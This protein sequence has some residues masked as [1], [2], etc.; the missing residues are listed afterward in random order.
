[1]LTSIA[2]VFLV[3]MFL[4]WLFKKI[5]LP[6]LI[7]MIVTGILLGPYVL[8]VLDDSIL[9]VSADLRQMAL[10]IILFR[11]GLSLKIDDF[12]KMGSSAIF[13]SFVPALFEIGAVLILGTLLFDLNLVEAALM[14]SVLA[15]VSPAVVVPSMLR[16]IEKGYGQE[17]RVPQLVLAGAA[18]D[19]I[20]VIVLFSSFLAL[21]LGSNFSAVTIIEVPLAI[22]IGLLTGSIIGWV[23]QLFYR[24]FHMRDTTKVIILLSL[25]FLLLELEELISEFIPF[26]GLLAIMA[27]GLTLNHFYP[28]LADRLSVKYNKLWTG[29][30]I[31]LF[32]LVGASVDVRYA[33]RAGVPVILLIIGALMMRMIGVFVSLLPSSLNKKEKFF[34]M[35]SYTPKATVQAAIGGVPLAMGLES[36]QLILTV[37]VLSILITAPL[38]SLAIEKTY[39]KLLNHSSELINN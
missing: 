28:I 12:K 6:S 9:V 25:S 26:S 11:A 33:L 37:A 7:G 4:G 5:G 27:L 10:V 2:L 22:I 13:M 29:A 35:I 21:A 15:A 3:G 24:R 39:K 30:Q 17:K 36:G 1:M 16:V 14:G 34:T 8:N 18:L 20:F 31:L 38:G 32:V 23:M 19:D